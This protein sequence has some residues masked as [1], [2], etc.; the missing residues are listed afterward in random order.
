MSDCKIRC[1][2][3][4]AF[5]RL[6]VVFVDAGIKIYDFERVGQIMRFLVNGVAGL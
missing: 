4:L 3:A 5:M 6:N 1:Y 2:K